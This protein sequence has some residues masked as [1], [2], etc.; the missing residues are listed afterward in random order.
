MPLFLNCKIIALQTFIVF[1]QNIN[2]NQSQ[3]Y[4]YLLP[5]EP[6][7]PSHP[8]RLSQRPSLSSLSHTANSH[9][10]SILHMVTYVSVLLSSNLPPSPDCPPQAV[11]ISLFSLSVSP[12]LLCKWVHQDHLSRFH[13]YASV[14]NYCLSVCDLLHS[15]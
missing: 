15:I 7:S 4:P 2:K 11:S 13:I 1:C 10:L 6:P 14:C 5:P 3:V 12:L 9:L 8:S